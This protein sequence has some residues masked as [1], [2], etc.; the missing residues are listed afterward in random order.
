[1]KFDYPAQMPG[2]RVSAVLGAVLFS[3]SGAAR[4]ELNWCNLTPALTASSFEEA[5]IAIRQVGCK[6]NPSDSA[7]FRSWKCDDRTTADTLIFA[8][9]DGALFYVS[10]IVPRDILDSFS[11]C[12]GVESAAKQFDRDSIAYRGG[13]QIRFGSYGISR[14]EVLFYELAGLRVVGTGSGYS[15]RAT[16]MFLEGAFYGYSRPTIASSSVEIGG[17]PLYGTPA[18]EII[19]ALMA[20]GSRLL[21]DKGVSE[22]A[23]K[24]T[25]LTA[26]IGLEGVT[27]IEVVSIG[28]HASTVRYTLAGTAAYEA[29]VAALDEKYGRSTRSGAQR[30]TTRQ[31]NASTFSAVRIIGEHCADSARVWFDNRVVRNQFDEFGAWLKEVSKDTPRKPS[32]DKDNI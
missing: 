8:D 28:P 3:T 26:P 10:A 15:E 31:W 17:K 27:E 16:K 29:I 22:G 1:M 20:R 30:C 14:R 19:D 9:R 25:S 32:I 2:R 21:T 4:A 13:A 12:P 18:K 6:E 24:V 5:V 7:H 11:S 23:G